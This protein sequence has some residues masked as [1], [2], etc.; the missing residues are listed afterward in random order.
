MNELNVKWQA[1]RLNSGSGGFSDGL[2][3]KSI[4]GSYDTKQE[5]IDALIASKDIP[6]T[7]NEPKAIF[8]KIVILEVY[9]I[10]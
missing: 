5:V 3:L 7:P 4:A 9:Q 2:T 1:F 8:G 6:S 10:N